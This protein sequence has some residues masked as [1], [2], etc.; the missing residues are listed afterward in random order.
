MRPASK[1]GK[2]VTSLR[3]LR[4]LI[5][6]GIGPDDP[7]VADLALMRRIRTLNGCCIGLLGAA[8]GTIILYAS[9]G[10]W[11]A[12]LGVAIVSL[13]SL[14]TLVGVR[15]GWNVVVSTHINM[16]SLLL[17][18]SFLGVQLGGLH[19]PGEAWI[20]VPA[21][22]AGLVLG[23]KVAALYTVLGTLP[24]LS[25]Y[26][27]HVAGVTLPTVLPPDVLPLYDASVLIMFGGMLLAVAC[28]FLNAQ[29]KAEEALRTANADLERSRDAAEAA[30]VA[31]SE[32]LAT[33]SHEIRT[34]MNGIFGM[35]E[36]ALDPDD[37]AA[38]RDFLVRARACAE[39][40]M[41]VIN[42]V[43]D[44]SK[45]EAGKLDLE[46]IEFDVRGVVDGVLDTL[47][48][49]AA[50]KKLELVGIVDDALP[51]RLRG[52]PGRLQQVIMNLA[53]NALKFTDHGE[54]VI[55][56]ERSD[57]GAA[58]VAAAPAETVMMRCAIRDTGIG[59]PV[60]KQR[61]IFESF[62]QADS[63]TTRRHGGTGLGLAISQRLVT[64]MGG[65]IDVES[66]PGMG[67][68]FSF[69][70]ALRSA[71]APRATHPPVELAG[72]RVLVVDDNATNRMFLLKT[73]QAWGC[74]AA[75]ASGGAEGFDLL[76]HAMRG[77]E[78]FGLV[79]LDMQMPDLDGD[80]TAQRIRNEP[81]TRDVP[82]IALTSISRSVTERARALGFA[83]LL[84]K[85]IKQ[86][87]L[88]EAILAGATDSGAE[89]GA[90]RNPPDR[91]SRGAAPAGSRPAAS[92]TS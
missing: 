3:M 91:T 78:P 73:L 19:A 17:L 62:T 38:R 7:R 27:L 16:V 43:L 56:L 26:A 44:F 76:V 90:A 11:K 41:T 36:L 24:I 5:D 31:K 58:D 33:M 74:R 2:S 48:I 71:E 66:A 30:T 1:L 25:Y 59:I 87:Q 15:R 46:C 67:S 60:D 70:A 89:L 6:A 35:T 23:A 28:A 82:I 32:F 92:R 88:L 72:L 20:F 51:T 18:L 61:H 47:A 4:N 69:T 80:A 8:P 79:L 83:A 54:I 50:R 9:V 52:D 81:T 49:E 63:S 37:D 57:V 45:I 42:D 85:P 22:F 64:M 10:A 39:N 84:P 68:T 34:P 75:L 13:V 77:G 40:L 29:D 65:T 55:R 21:M 86:T 12:Y 53:G 14:G